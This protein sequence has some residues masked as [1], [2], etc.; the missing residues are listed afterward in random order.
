MMVAEDKEKKIVL[1]VEMSAEN[2]K[3]SHTINSD[4]QQTRHHHNDYKNKIDLR[5]APFLWLQTFF[6]M[7]T[8]YEYD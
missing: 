2:T 7:S 6:F 4:Y 3:T 1:R 8:Y 5:L